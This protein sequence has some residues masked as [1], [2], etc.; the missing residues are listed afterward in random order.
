MVGRA[1]SALLLLA[2]FAPCA[3]AE[4]ESPDPKELLKSIR[5]LTEQDEKIESLDVRVKI[6]LEGGLRWTL[7]ATYRKPD[8]HA[9]CLSD[10][11]G[12]PI[13]MAS[14]GRLL[15]FDSGNRKVVC[16]NE[17]KTKNCIRVLKD[18]KGNAQFQFG[19]MSEDDEKAGEPVVRVDI[20]SMFAGC[21][22]TLAAARKEKLVELSARTDRGSELR[23]SLLPGTEFPCVAF[24]GRVKGQKEPAASVQIRVN[25]PPDITFFSLPDLATLSKYV[26]VETVPKDEAAGEAVRRFCQTWMSVLM[27]RAV[28]DT[29]EGRAAAEEKLGRKIDWDAVKEFDTTLADA[30]REAMKPTTP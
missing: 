5:V 4:P 27:V 28:P 9:L 12:L 14:D 16:M 30:L 25:Q 10:A 6:C 2:L 19:T 20:A 17:A 24:K 23:A 29:A 22:E 26:A 21:E 7:R 1:C 15:V 13:L 18:E 11:N 8:R 3:F